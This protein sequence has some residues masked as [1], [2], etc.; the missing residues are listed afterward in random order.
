MYYNNAAE[1][2][3]NIENRVVNKLLINGYKIKMRSSEKCIAT[4]ISFTI[5]YRV[6]R[7]DR[8]LSS[9][10]I[11]KFLHVAV[12]SLRRAESQAVAARN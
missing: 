4:R 10:C 11:P 5:D 6:P 3:L 1:L 8:P 2:E 12:K 7:C 9:V